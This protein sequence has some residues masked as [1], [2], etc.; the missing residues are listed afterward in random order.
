MLLKKWE[1]CL[2]IF[3]CMLAF[4][5]RYHFLVTYRYPMMIHEQD[6]VGYMVVAKN[7]F[8]LQPL[9]TAGRPPGYPLVIALFALL[10]VDLE[11]AARLAS[12]F[13]DA[14]TV[15]PLFILARIYLSRIPALAVCLLWAFFSFS[16]IFTTSPLSQSSY[17]CYLLWGIVLL[18]Q[19][20]EKNGKGWLCGAGI[21]FALSYLAR[22]EGFVGFVCGFLVCLL[23]LIGK[24][25]F[26]RKKVAAPLVFLLGFLLLA[27]PYLI[28]LHNHIGQWALSPL[29]ESH[30]K[31]ADVVL[32]LNAKGEL[33][34]TGTGGSVWKDY[35]GT[36]PVFIDAVWANI[37]A[38]S[39]VYYSTFPIWMHL[40]SWAG[41]VILLWGRRAKNFIYMLILLAVTSP[42]YIVTIPKTH[43]YIY[44]IFTVMFVC[45]IAFFETAAKGVWRVVEKFRP[46]MKSAVYEAG[47]S[48]L[49]LL[50]VSYVSFGFYKQA[51]ANYQSPELVRQVM[52][53]EK[54]YKGAGEIIKNNSQK[55]DVIMTRWGLVGYFADR[56]VI[57]LPKGGV[58]EVV[59]YGRKNGARFLL[60]DTNSVLSRRQELIELLGP[61]EGKPV[62]PAYGIEVLSGNYFPDLGGFVIY[63]YLLK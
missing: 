32:T 25:N 45:F 28:S 52:L 36:V 41:M 37:K 3:A 59:D 31:T 61:L 62:N 51:D 42:N 50:V 57:T 20:V 27:G 43:S 11:Y 44:P 33:K 14:L 5:L 16:L 12:I 21:L 53:T 34:K 4:A 54:I 26:N 23:P 56:P 49:L 47:L 7:I 8:Q 55:N 39:R 18:H 63:R 24:G 30:V 1:Y 58:K 17:L 46:V 60:I 9:D 10:P 29:T 22:P 35:Y 6:A 38:F 13:M 15:L 40:V 48:V 19:G 2:P